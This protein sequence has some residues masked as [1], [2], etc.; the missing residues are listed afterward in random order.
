MEGITDVDE[1]THIKI[2]AKKD[3]SK[4]KKDVGKET[5]LDALKTTQKIEVKELEDGTI[6][7][8][9]KTVTLSSIGIESTSE[10]YNA[11]WDESIGVKTNSTVYYD[12]IYSGSI[13][14]VKHMGAK[15]GWQIAD[16]WLSVSSKRVR[17]GI[18][19][20]T[21]DGTTENKYKDYYP[22]GSTFSYG[23]PGWRSVRGDQYFTKLGAT[24]YAKISDGSETWSLEMENSY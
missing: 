20:M 13:L 24:T 17:L 19:G 10:L 12:K 9:Y 22:S 18:F 21:S 4:D 3:K 23:S 7:E 2:K 8:S 6:V 16:S 5:E 1:S 11:K 15:G 14:Y